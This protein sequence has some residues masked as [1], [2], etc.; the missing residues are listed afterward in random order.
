MQDNPTNL[1]FPGP[2]GSLKLCPLETAQKIWK[3]KSAEV[4]CSEHK[5]LGERYT[6]D[7]SEEQWHFF[8]ANFFE[9]L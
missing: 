2:R 8:R 1:T 6:G 3:E 9:R 4:L 5:D 7:H